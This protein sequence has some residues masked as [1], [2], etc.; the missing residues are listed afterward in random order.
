ML[1]SKAGLELFLR[2]FAAVLAVAATR[3]RLACRLRGILLLIR[4]FLVLALVGLL[5]LLFYVLSFLL[6]IDRLLRFAVFGLRLLLGSRLLLF[7]LLLLFLFFLIRLR[8]LRPDGGNARQ[9]K[10]SPQTP[11]FELTSYLPS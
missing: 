5:L 2:N 3:I 11:W 10:K 8:F 4:L 1:P 7:F 6:L 9:R